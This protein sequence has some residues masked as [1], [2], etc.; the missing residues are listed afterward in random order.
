MGVMFNL[1]VTRHVYERTRV[2]EGLRAEEEE[3]ENIYQP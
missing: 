2:A 3:G 1:S